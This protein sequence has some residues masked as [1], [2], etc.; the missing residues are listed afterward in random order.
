MKRFLS[1]LISISIIMISLSMFLYVYANDDAAKE[2]REAMVQMMIDEDVVR[3]D[4]KGDIKPYDKVTRA[5]MAAMII[6]KLGKED[7][8]LSYSDSATGFVDDSDIAE[9]ERAYI[10]Y[11]ED[12]DMV[13][14]YPDGTVRSSNNVTYEEGVKFVVC[15]FDSAAERSYPDGYIERAQE[16]GYLT[17]VEGILGL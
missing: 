1:L 11:G 10:A 5:E 15:A 16:L 6:R 7:K 9:W 14:G 4:E 17:G 3:G 12:I 2:H 8:A 13:D